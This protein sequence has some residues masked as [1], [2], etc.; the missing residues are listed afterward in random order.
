VLS[1]FGWLPGWEGEGCERV[2]R[3]GSAGLEKI[4]VSRVLSESS[5]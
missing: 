4:S 5:T 2:G 3:S 1:V